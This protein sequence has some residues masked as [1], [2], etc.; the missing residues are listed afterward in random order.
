MEKFLAS[1]L[2]AVFVLV[3]FVYAVRQSALEQGQKMSDLYFDENRKHI[4]FKPTDEEMISNL[5]FL[6]EAEIITEDSGTLI[7]DFKYLVPPEDKSTYRI[8]FSPPSADFVND[9]NILKPGPNTIRLGVHFQPEFRL[10]RLY[11]GEKI[12][13]YIYRKLGAGKEQQVFA[14]RAVFEKDWRRSRR[15]T[16]PLIRRSKF[17]TK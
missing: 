16:V 9:N 2:I 10:K 17:H 11:K 14:R 4:K 6:I 13:F 15:S 3:G 1:F 7:L 12:G 5:P 8:S